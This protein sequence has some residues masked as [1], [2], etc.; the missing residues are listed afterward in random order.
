MVP[1]LCACA[2]LN[3]S[4]HL[5]RTAAFTGG[6]KE[7][8]DD[9]RDALPQPQGFGGNLMYS[10]EQRHH[11]MQPCCRPIWRTAAKSVP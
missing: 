11:A 3:L 5:Y 7:E 9:T 10:W 4:A 8:E 2:L 6:C 1:C